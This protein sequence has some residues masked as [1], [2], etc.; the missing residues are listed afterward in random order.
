MLFL[1]RDEIEELIRQNKLGYVED[2]SNSLVKYARN[3]IRHEVIPK[4]KELNP[5]L[6][7]T[8]EKN[9]SRFRELETLLD[10]RVAELRKKMF[11]Y[12]EGDVQIAITAIKGLDPQ[13]LLLF[14]LLQEYGFNESTVDDIISSLDKHAGRTFE[15]GSFMLVLD[16]DNIIISPKK[17]QPYHPVQ[18]NEANHDVNYGNYKITIL[19]D[20]SPLIVKDNPFATSI[21]AGSLTYPLTIRPWKEGDNFYPLG[22]K[23]K[24]KLSDFFIHQ[25]IPV[26]QKSNIPLLINGNGDIMWIAGYRLNDKYKVSKNTKKVIIF[27]LVKT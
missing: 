24:Q 1:S 3:K 9:L 6:E 22:M 2:S 21:D 23:T 7:I 20:D 11:V 12:E 26:H 5:A 4:L 18:I 19:H 16:R 10:L 15:S 14:M 8:F 25:K 13:R 27:E 17:T